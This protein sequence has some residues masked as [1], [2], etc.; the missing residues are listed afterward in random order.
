MRKTIEGSAAHFA[1]NIGSRRRLLP[2]ESCFRALEVGAH[3]ACVRLVPWAADTDEKG[4]AARP[5]TTPTRPYL[6]QQRGDRCSDIGVEICPLAYSAYS[7]MFNCS[8]LLAWQ[9]QCPLSSN[10]YHRKLFIGKCQLS[11]ESVVVV[12]SL[13][14]STSG[15]ISTRLRLL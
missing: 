15:F 2:C 13:V 6:C 5:L 14:A 4:G 8:L 10:H 1:R 12:V 3:R 7:C 9:P 11:A